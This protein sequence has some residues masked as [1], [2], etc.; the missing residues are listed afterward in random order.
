MQQ[1]FMNKAADHSFLFPGIAIIKYTYFYR[2]RYQVLHNIF[3]RNSFMVFYKL[4]FAF[5]LAK[6]DPLHSNIGLYDEWIREPRLLN[7]LLYL[8]IRPVMHHVNSSGNK[9][10]GQLVIHLLFP[11]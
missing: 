6:Q 8:I 9:L 4:L 2:K 3:Y 7:L 10:R 1:L 11:F 5:N